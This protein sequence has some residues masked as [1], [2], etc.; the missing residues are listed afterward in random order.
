MDS[1]NTKLISDPSNIQLLK[2]LG[3]M[4]EIKPEC[5]NEYRKLHLESNHGI[6]DLLVKYQLRNY[7]MF[8]NQLDNRWFAFAYCEY[9][10]R[11]FETDIRALNMDVR[12]LEWQD[13]CQKMYVT[14][15]INQG[16]IDME[17]IFFNP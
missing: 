17:Q 10:G 13:I 5:L 11:D 4:C 2:R 12:Y 14:T 16:W 9:A 8:L 15:D 7:S 6:R 3:M 1:Y